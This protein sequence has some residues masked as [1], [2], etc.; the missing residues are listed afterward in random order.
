MLPANER[1]PKQQVFLVLGLDSGRLLPSTRRLSMIST[2][3]ARYLCCGSRPVQFLGI[4]ETGDAI[5]SRLRSGN[6]PSRALP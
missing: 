2:A 5:V 1:A 4:S 3:L 6:E